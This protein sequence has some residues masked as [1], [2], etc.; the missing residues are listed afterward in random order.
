[1]NTTEE[2]EFDYQAYMKDYVPDP[3]EIHWGLEARQKRREAAIHNNH[4]LAYR[5]E[6]DYDRAIESFTKAIELNPNYAEAYNNRGNAYRD[7]GNFDR[8]IADYTK[9][10]ELKPDFVEAYN[11]RDDAYYAKGDYDHAIVEYR[12]IT[13]KGYWGCL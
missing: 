9:A 13:R 12:D 3:D 6:G 4:G 10:I 7:N 11:H 1:M 2:E 5:D 8:A